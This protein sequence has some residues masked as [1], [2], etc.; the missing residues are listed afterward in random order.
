MFTIWMKLEDIILDEISQL[1]RTNTVLL[2]YD[3]PKV[4]KII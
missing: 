4:V 1:Q 3:V 2:L